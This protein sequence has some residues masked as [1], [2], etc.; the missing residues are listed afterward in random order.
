MIVTFFVNVQTGQKYHMSRN[1]DFSKCE[2]KNKKKHI[3]F[4]NQMLAAKL[5]K[6]MNQYV[7]II[8]KIMNNMN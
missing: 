7:H 2:K 4:F 1:S 3:E 8:R 5:M 6:Q